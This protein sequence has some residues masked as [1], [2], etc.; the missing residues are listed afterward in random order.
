MTTGVMAVGEDVYNETLVIPWVNMDF[1]SVYL[2]MPGVAMAIRLIMTALIPWNAAFFDSQ[3]SGLYFSST[4][5]MPFC[6]SLME[7]EMH[8]KKSCDSGYRTRS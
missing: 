4:R 7:F 3:P 6:S 1:D 2:P 8:V 5:A